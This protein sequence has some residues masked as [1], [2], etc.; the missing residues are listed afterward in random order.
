[1]GVFL[2]IG[3]LLP[4]EYVITE[5]QLKTILEQSKEPAMPV[6]IKLFKLLNEEKK[7]NKTRASLLQAIEKLAP[8]INVPKEYALYLLELYLLNYRKDGNYS[9]LTK[10][11]FVD[12]RKMK[13][14][15]TSNPNAKL[16]TVAQLPFKGSNLEG[17]W[18]EDYNGKPYYKVVS[19]RWYPVYIFKDD[20]W[21]EV[22][23]RYSS[24]T[25]KQIRNANPVKWD[26][27]LDSVVYTLTK[28]EM[29]ML[30][31]GKSHDEVMK[32]KL[33][34]LK[35][36]EP[37]IS[38]RKKTEKIYNSYGFEN[39][40]NAN[41]KFK[42]KSVD[43]EGDKAIVTI[44]VYDVLK[45]EGNKSI[46]TPQNYLRGEI[47]NLTTK[48]VEDKIASKMRGELKDYTGT[49]QRYTHEIPPGTKIEFKFNHLKK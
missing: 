13:G 28:D 19:Y 44:D 5:N 17:Y 46:P 26:D 15:T 3:Y 42:V 33:E 16:Y 9:G 12:P 43:I 40:A 30:E 49:R 29:K 22:T 45:R 4:M 20:K 35:S 37:E 39:P 14:K 41:I 38:K 18:D 8:Y 34:K 10:E 11:N 36:V 24:S 47:P 27:Y 7:K 1:M 21:Y 48:K 31:H 23:E 25:S 6:I 2:F 32:T